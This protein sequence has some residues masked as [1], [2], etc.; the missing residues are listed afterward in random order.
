ME[1]VKN[2]HYT[3]GQKVYYS[4]AKIHGLRDELFRG[5]IIKSMKISVRIINT[6]GV[7]E[8]VEKSNLGLVI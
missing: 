3:K 6:D 7:V 4:E 1:S 5:T 8:T 2:I